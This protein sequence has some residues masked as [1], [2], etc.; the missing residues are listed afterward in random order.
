[1]QILHFDNKPHNILFNENF[2]PKVFD[3]ELA[4]LYPI[5][6]SII[7]LIAANSKIVL[8]KYWDWAWALRWVDNCGR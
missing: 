4:K 1:M 3:F 2:T 7:S 8:Q 5:N 6:D